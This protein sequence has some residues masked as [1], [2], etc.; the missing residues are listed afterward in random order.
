MLNETHLE[1]AKQIVAAHRTKKRCNDCYDRGWLGTNEEGLLVPCG[2]CTDIEAAM[3]EWK[4]YVASVP[5]LKEQFPEL[6]EEPK[7]ET[8]AE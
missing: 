2:R 6:F 7:E 3:A 5:E 8:T 4:D 1:R